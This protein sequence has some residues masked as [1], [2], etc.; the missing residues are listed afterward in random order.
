MGFAFQQFPQMTA[1][2]CC[3][4]LQ[5]ATVCEFVCVVLI[6]TGLC[7]INL[8]KKDLVLSFLKKTAFR[9][10]AKTG[11]EQGSGDSSWAA[12]LSG[13]VSIERNTSSLSRL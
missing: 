11:F 6:K 13:L 4:A 12:R 8:V 10:G 9:A 7:Q 1:A 5:N 2:F 3:A